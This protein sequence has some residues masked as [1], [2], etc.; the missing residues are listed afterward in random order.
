MCRWCDMR[1]RFKA[2][3]WQVSW[4]LSPKQ[5]AESAATIRHVIRPIP[6]RSV[7]SSPANILVA[8]LNNVTVFAH[9]EASA[10]SGRRREVSTGLS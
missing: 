3:D 7:C 10:A 9:E 4:P 5:P 8:G 1:R 2:S 6:C